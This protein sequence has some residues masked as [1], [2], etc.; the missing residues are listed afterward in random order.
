MAH[1]YVHP[2][3]TT[4]AAEHRAAR[5]P[6]RGD[7]L[8][9]IPAGASAGFPGVEVAGG[10]K[11]DPGRLLVEHDAFVAELPCR[12][13]AKYLRRRGTQQLLATYPS[14]EVWMTRPVA[15]RIAEAPRLQASCRRRF[16]SR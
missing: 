5:A 6:D 14:L 3:A 7:M 1:G 8:T 2:S 4:L 15:G 12:S 16:G 9:A 11:L 10:G 13:Q